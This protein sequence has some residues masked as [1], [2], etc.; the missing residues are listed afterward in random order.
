VLNESHKLQARGFWYGE[1]R[2]HHITWKL[3]RAIRLAVESF[4][5]QLRGRNVLLYEDNTTVFI[6]LTKLTSCSTVRMTE[7]NHLWFLLDTNNIRIRP[8]YIRLAA[9]NTWTDSLKR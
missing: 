9:I 7:L 5:S 8:R 3:L 1:D 6:S 2:L 4:V